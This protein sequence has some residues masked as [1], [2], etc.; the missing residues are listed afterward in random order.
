MVTRMYQIA[1]VLNAKPAK[2]DSADARR[3]VLMVREAITVVDA[4][5]SI[6]PNLGVADGRPVGYFAGT[7]RSIAEPEH[8]LHET[9][10]VL[11]RR[12]AERWGQEKSPRF[13]GLASIGATRFEL[14]TSTSRT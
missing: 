5:P 13:A 7:A 14:A 9:N 12:R 8:L 6:D 4:P 11:W 1:E 3:L 2:L 10:R